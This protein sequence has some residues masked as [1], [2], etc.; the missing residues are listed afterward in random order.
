MIRL[1]CKALQFSLT[2]PR[3]TKCMNLRQDEF[4]RSIS[5]IES[6]VGHVD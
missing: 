3:R 1:R 6:N 2:V 4:R 5:N